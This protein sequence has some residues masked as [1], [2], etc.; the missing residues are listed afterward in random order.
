MLIQTCTNA[1]ERERF[2]GKRND[3]FYILTMSLIL[4]Y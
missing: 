2:I 3:N 4:M 1:R